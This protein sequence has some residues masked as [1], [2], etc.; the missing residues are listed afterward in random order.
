MIAPSFNSSR[1]TSSSINITWNPIPC[2]RRGVNITGYKVDLTRAGQG[3]SS[4]SL[5]VLTTSVQFDS[6]SPCTSYTITV[7]TLN[8]GG[9]TSFDHAERTKTI[10]ICK[11]QIYYEIS[12]LGSC[13]YSLKGIYLMK[14]QSCFGE[15]YVV[16]CNL[17][18]P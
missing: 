8:R 14:M 15:R 16:L 10:G 6:L 18:L 17:F 1:V 12:L 5:N 2:G 13:C 7:T 3:Q 11:Q 9:S 4:Q